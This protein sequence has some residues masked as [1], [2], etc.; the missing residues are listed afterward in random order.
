MKEKIAESAMHL[1]N[2]EVV[3]DLAQYQPKKKRG[4]RSPLKKQ[5]KHNSKAK[6]T[7]IIT[8]ELKTLICTEVASGK[9]L[10]SICRDNLICKQSI[11]DA[12]MIDPEF[13]DRYAYARERQADSYFDEIRDIIDGCPADAAEVQLA[14]LKMDALKWACGKLHPKK[15]SDKAAVELTGKDGGAVMIA[16][17]PIIEFSIDEDD[18]SDSE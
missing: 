17:A 16:P 1:A 13:A 4:V 6:N 9:T 11:Y 5:R 7:G 18:E 15:Y 8:P 2:G 12:M 14:R 3:D 10:N